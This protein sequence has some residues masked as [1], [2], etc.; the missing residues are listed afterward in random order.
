MHKV[1]DHPVVTAT[2]FLMTMLF[3]AEVFKVYLSP[4]QRKT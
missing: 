3:K 4:L 2:P 1:R